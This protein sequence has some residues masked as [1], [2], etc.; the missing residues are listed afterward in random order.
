ML[1]LPF[2]IRLASLGLLLGGVG[3]SAQEKGDSPG[4][5]APSYENRKIAGWELRI[6]KR[7]LSKEKGRTEKAVVL[8]KGQLDQVTRLVP[9]GPLEDLRKVTIWMSPIYPGVPPTAE[10]HPSQA[11][12]KDHGRNPDMARGIEI[13]NVANFESECKRMPMLM[14]HELAHAYHDRVLGFDHAGIRAAYERAKASG[15]YDNVE[16]KFANGSTRIE[17]AYAMT[18]PQEYFAEAT[19][20]YFGINDWFPYNRDQLKKHD[21]EMVELLGQLWKTAKTSPAKPKK[22][23]GPQ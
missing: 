12:L 23:K 10:Y 15:K 16:R 20:A 21:P 14:L 11:W 18:N 6:D 13:T 22:T 3:L 5:D 19:E 4:Q 8:L 7:L 2:L 1:D 9:P 17:K